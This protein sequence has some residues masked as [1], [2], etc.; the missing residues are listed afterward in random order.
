MREYSISKYKN[1]DSIYEL[2]KYNKVGWKEEFIYDNKLYLVFIRPD[3]KTGGSEV[4]FRQLLK[5]DKKKNE[6]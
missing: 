4:V 2:V 5:E 3:K 1:I 6:I